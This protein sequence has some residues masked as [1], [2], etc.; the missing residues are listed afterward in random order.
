M[1]NLT[2]AV[3]NDTDDQPY[4]TSGVEW[5]DVNLSN[6]EIY[7]TAGLSGVVEDGQSIPSASELTQAGI[8]LEGVEK[9]VDLYLLADASVN[10]LKEIHNMGNQNKRYVIAFDFD[11]ATASEPVLEVWDDDDLDSIDSTVLGSGNPASSFFRGIVTTDA[12]P[13]ADWVGSRL[14]GASTGYFLWLNNQ[15]GP[16]SG[17]KTLYCN[18]KVIVPSTVTEGTAESPVIAVK[19]TSN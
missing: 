19:Y 11:G 6:D 4:G 9:I 10:E 17:A 7:F 13:G 12:L 2:I 1:T 18:M 8:R 3:N 15:A 5:T 14:A 16:L